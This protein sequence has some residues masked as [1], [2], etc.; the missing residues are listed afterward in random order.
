MTDWKMTHP[1]RREDPLYWKWVDYFL[2][3]E[4]GDDEE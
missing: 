3:D 4:T 2:A 1:T